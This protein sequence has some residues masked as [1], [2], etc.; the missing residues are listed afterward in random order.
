VRSHVSKS[1]KKTDI[2]AVVYDYFFRF[3]EDWK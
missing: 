2:I 1:L 3:Y